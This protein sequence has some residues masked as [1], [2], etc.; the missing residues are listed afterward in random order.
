M[1]FKDI[2][3]RFGGATPL[4]EM[5]ISVKFGADLVFYE[6]DKSAVARARQEAGTEENNDEEEE[7]GRPTAKS[8]QI[9]RA[10]SS[11]T[12]LATAPTTPA[13]APSWLRSCRG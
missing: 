6:F 13:T 7:G 9:A 8:S 3:R 12:G 5:P 1:T 4:R 10:A 2:K 11:R